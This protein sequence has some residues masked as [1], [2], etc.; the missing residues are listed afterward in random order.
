[1][2]AAEQLSRWVYGIAKYEAADP[3][4]PARLLRR[5]VGDDH[6]RFA[7]GPVGVR[8]ARDG[9][10]IVH[11][12]PGLRPES[13]CVCMGIA[14][15][16][17]AIAVQAPGRAGDRAFVERVAMAIVMPAAAVTRAIAALGSETVA[18]ARAFVVPEPFAAVRMRRLHFRLASG[19]F[20]RADWRSAG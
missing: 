17:I 4:G 1:M 6:I 18:I 13:L 5:I 9:I 15:A 14:L 2:Q 16:Q 10:Q 3:P 20:L 8:V 7:S 12:P 11:I 19:E